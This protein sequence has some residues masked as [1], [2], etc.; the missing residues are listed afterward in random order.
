MYYNT[1]DPQKHYV[2]FKNPLAKKYTLRF[3]SYEILEQAKPN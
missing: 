3:H 1:D 2:E